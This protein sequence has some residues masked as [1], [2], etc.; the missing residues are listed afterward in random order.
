MAPHDRASRCRAG[1]VDAAMEA[2]LGSPEGRAAGTYLGNFATGTV[3]FLTGDEDD[4][5]LA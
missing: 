5:T 4:V 3:A 2:R 1:L